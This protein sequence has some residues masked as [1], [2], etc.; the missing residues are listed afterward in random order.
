MIFV[1][2]SKVLNFKSSRAI[3]S[4]SSIYIDYNTH[5]LVVTVVAKEIIV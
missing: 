5:F 2:F 3:E 1:S 4:C